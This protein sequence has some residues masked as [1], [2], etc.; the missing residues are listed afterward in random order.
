MQASD[1]E[2]FEVKCNLTTETATLLRESLSD[3]V[4]TSLD[5]HNQVLSKVC[6]WAL[7]VLV[8]HA[9]QCSCVHA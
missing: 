8:A 6:P 9:A 3:L 4:Q 7:L 1:V 5:R 2:G